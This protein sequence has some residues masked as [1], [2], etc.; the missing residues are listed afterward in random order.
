MTIDNPTPRPTAPKPLDPRTISALAPLVPLKR[1]CGW[2]YVWKDGKWTKPPAQ[3]TTNNPATWH[4]FDDIW[5][6]MLQDTFDGI[7]YMLLKLRSAVFDLDDVRDPQT[8]AL[9][10]WADKLVKD[11]DT[12][13]EITVSGCGLR[14]IGY[15]PADYPSVH[16]KKPH[17]SGVGS[18]EVYAN[19][20]TG[21][22]RY[23]T[24]SGHQLEGTPDKLRDI[25]DIV[26]QF[27]G[28]PGQRKNNGQHEPI[29]GGEVI[30]LHDIMDP[31]I[32]D[33]IENGA[34]VGERS[35]R[36]WD[37]VRHLRRNG[38][39][40]ADV[41]A[42][43]EA[44]PNGIAEKYAGRLESQLRTV[45]EEKL[46]DEPIDGE[47]F[48]PESEPEQPQ[49]EPQPRAIWDPW[50]D[51]PPPMWPGGILSPPLEKALISI[52][53][54]DGLDPGL[55]CTAALAGVSAAAHKA[56]RFIPYQPGTKDE[57]GLWSVPPVIWVVPVADSGFRKSRY[58]EIIFAALWEREK[59]EWRIH[60]AMHD[61][62][63]AM[64]KGANKGPEP[65]APPDYVITDFTPEGL[66]DALH[67]SGRGTALVVD[68]LVSLLEFD[69]YRGRA[70]G[71]NAG[72]GWLLSTF[73]DK[74]QRVVRADK[75]GKVLIEHTG[76][77]MFGG[78]QRRRIAALK[79]DLETDGF[80]QRKCTIMVPP[81][82]GSQPGTVVPPG[83]DQY[84]A[85]IDR[86]CT[87]APRTY[88]T[89]QAGSACIKST[90]DAGKDYAGIS[91]YGEGWPGFA[92]KL[93][94]LHARFAL[95]LHLLE[96]PDADII[97]TERVERAHRLIHGFVLQHARDFHGELLGSAGDTQRDIA[98]WLLTRASAGPGKRERIVASD[99]TNG[100]RSC[101]NLAS[102]G[103]SEV[104]D[105]FVT[106]GW[107]VPETNYPSNR[108]WLFDPNIRNR[109]A[110]RAQT[111]R[112]RRA[113]V[114]DLIQRMAKDRTTP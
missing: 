69:R 29:G 6:L 16:T 32:A 111:E 55:L 75:K 42:T 27:A 87:F 13:T 18:Y 107:L 10:G 71:A 48:K 20:G 54:R 101:R 26:Q 112:D 44:H 83:M 45:F 113:E 114:R 12:Y 14:I 34:P 91:D 100:V 9:E 88:T 67:G 105:R 40:L 11:A 61:M 104:L 60:Q 35:N 99:L 56:I 2:N 68:E 97:P 89:T 74:P 58:D 86:L 1:W 63:Q 49:P 85:A 25:A 23:I 73:D 28:A 72:R 53:A 110:A 36:F 78:I 47:E 8:G 81:S 93:H 79:G 82:A 24:V 39:S 95:L 21:H 22:A 106:G 52:A 43:L 76:C 4:A 30:D 80:L 38:H 64:P 92:Y 17:P 46:A 109:F 94:G 103:I 37:V 15:V 77:A 70:G 19:L 90:E 108:S 102:K 62:W 7:G 3:A 5:K 65:K 41:F 51:P 57:Q 66:R 96:D 98:G 33:L 59:E 31:R 84:N 50:G